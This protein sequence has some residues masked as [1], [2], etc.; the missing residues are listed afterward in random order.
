MN[1][2]ERHNQKTHYQYNKYFNGNYDFI[3]FTQVV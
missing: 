2:N 1:I 3:K